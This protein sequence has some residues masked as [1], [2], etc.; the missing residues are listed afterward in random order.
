QCNFSKPTNVSNNK[1]LS[2]EEI[3]PED[4]ARQD[5]RRQ[6][7][8]HLCYLEAMGPRGVC[9]YLHHLCHQWLKPEQHTK[10]QMLDLV[11]L[12]QFLA[13]LP[14]EMQNWVRECE[15][16]SSSEAVALA[17]GFLLSKAE[18]AKQVRGSYS[19]SPQGFIMF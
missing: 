15:P 18:D 17:E 8:R 13:V 4:Q 9:S 3:L 5:E 19:G 14:L 2:Q 6:Q 7:F 10:A 11:V 1:N 12:E 16:E